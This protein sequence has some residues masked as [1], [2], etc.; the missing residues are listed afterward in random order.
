METTAVVGPAVAGIRPE[1][2]SGSAVFGNLDAE[3]PAGRSGLAAETSTSAWVSLKAMPAEDAP[4]DVKDCE[5]A[6]GNK[7]SALQTFLVADDKIK[8]R[9]SRMQWWFDIV[10]GVKAQTK[11]L[12]LWW[13]LFLDVAV[14]GIALHTLA[15]AEF[16][17]CP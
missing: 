17:T 12:A 11:P 10:I 15:A 4:A 7:H 9:R 2:V 1:E 5:Q 8:P 6:G 3:V 16:G 13:V 14:L